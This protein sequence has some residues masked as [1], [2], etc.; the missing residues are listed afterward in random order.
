ME[1]TSGL[2][3]PGHYNK[4]ALLMRWPLTVYVAM[5]KYSPIGSVKGGS[6]PSQRECV[7]V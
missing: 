2:S 3:G 1:D 6:S 5:P 4:V 7:W